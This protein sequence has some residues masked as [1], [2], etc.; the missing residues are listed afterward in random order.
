MRISTSQYQTTMLRGLQENQSWM[1]R[2]NEQM[3]T[4]ERIM[5]PSDD[6]VGNVQVSRLTR[7]EAQIAQYR[8]NI[9]AVKLRMNS[10]EAYLTS[11]VADIT[12][13]SD[14]MVQAADGSN[15]PDDLKAIVN[16][17][18]S[19]RDSLL[20]TANQKDSEGRYVFAGTNVN[21][22]PLALNAGGEYEY[23]GN[24]ADQLTTVGNGITQA[25]NV[26]LKGLEALLNSMNTTI[27]TLA[28][29]TA[30]AN[31]PAVRTIIT[32]TLAQ[33]KTGLDLVSGKIA[34]LG[35]AQ[36]ILKTLDDNHANVSLS[37]QTA[38]FDLSKLDFAQAATE[39]SGYSLAVE[40][41]YK[42]Y[43]KVSGLSL[44][45]LL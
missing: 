12:S 44:F 4:G 17:L 16:S 45:N 33:S 27:N 21:D 36:N 41:S 23:L 7:E 24:E 9:G 20:F 42:A 3:A 37:N 18:T 38:L 2:I 31:D 22:A 14:L 1:S 10:N 19:L 29:G 32:D 39:L 30:S 13:V 43:S 8:D 5:L 35:G 40:A 28:T 15:T 6:P 25:T 11:M 26:N 34:R